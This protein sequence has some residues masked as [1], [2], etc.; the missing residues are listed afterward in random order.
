MAA[1]EAVALTKDAAP[2]EKGADPVLNEGAA[3]PTEEKG[4][5]PVLNEGDALPTEEKGAD[6]VVQLF[7]QL[8]EVTFPKEHGETPRE[9]LRRASA[10]LEERF[11]NHPVMLACFGQNGGPDVAMFAARVHMQKVVAAARRKKR[12]HCLVKQTNGRRPITVPT[13][14]LASVSS[15]ANNE[16]SVLIR[17]PKG[18][19]VVSAIAPKETVVVVVPPPTRKRSTLAPVVA[20]TV[21]AHADASESTTEYL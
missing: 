1:N 15:D 5:D 6:P 8:L 3:L 17:D 16:I 21:V 19:Y 4:A 13:E 14:L 11:G 7:A 10:L 9:W 20:R 18:A 2:E 12:T